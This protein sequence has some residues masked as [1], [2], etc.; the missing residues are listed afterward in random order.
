VV[1]GLRGFTGGMNIGDE[2]AG[3]DTHSLYFRTLAELGIPGIA[4]LLGMIFN[5][6]RVLRL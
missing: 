2:Y 4:V 5:A 1:D 6:A 3:R